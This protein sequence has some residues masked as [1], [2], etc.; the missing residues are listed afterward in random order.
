MLLIQADAWSLTLTTWQCKR[1]AG[2]L[3][4]LGFA[5]GAP[6]L[7]GPS[8]PGNLGASGVFSGLSEGHKNHVKSKNKPKEFHPPSF[9]SAI[10][11]HLM[12]RAGFA[13]CHGE[14]RKDQE[15]NC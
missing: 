8:R 11:S 14:I 13:P 9:G 12:N 7:A 3:F 2:C 5:A 6:R 15:R 1:D 4:P 10:C